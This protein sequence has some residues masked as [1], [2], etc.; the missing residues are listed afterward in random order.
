MNIHFLPPEADAFE[1][2]VDDVV[3]ACGGDL[4]GALKALLMVN[5]LLE[6][7]LSKMREMLTK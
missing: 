3:A 7:E 4:R 2:A 6:R 5:D 1:I